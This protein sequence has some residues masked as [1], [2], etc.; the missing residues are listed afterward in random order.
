MSGADQQM[1]FIFRVPVDSGWKGSWDGVRTI[2]AA[3]NY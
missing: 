1:E 3:A 2:E